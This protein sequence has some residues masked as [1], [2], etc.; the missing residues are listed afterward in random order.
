ML[1]ATHSVGGAALNLR[2]GRMVEANRIYVLDQLRDLRD[3]AQFIHDSLLADRP[4]E[5][6]KRAILE[7]YMGEEFLREAERASLDLAGRLQRITREIESSALPA[8]QVK[9]A[10]R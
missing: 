1:N 6:G 9:V 10:S 7:A 5:K 2:G 4:Y 8:Q 3:W